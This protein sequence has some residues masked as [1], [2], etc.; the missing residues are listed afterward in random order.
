MPSP[1]G[2]ALPTSGYAIASL[3]L[4]LCWIWGIGS[5]LALVFAHQARQE[6]DANRKAGRAMA[7]AGHVL[8][9]IGLGLVVLAVLVA[10]GG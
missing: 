7:T 9:C 3:V 2:A 4:G 6:I 10:S 5:I 1:A 8:G